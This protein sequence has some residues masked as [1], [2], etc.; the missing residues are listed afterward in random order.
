VYQLST[1]GWIQ[2][3]DK[4][5][6]NDKQMLKCN[7]LNVKSVWIQVNVYVLVT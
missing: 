6:G 3:E 2:I 5:K 1:S 4:K 7:S